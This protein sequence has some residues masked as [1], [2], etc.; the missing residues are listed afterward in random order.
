MDSDPR[1]K[2][3][4]AMALD[5]CELRGAHVD[6]RCGPKRAELGHGN[7]SLTRYREPWSTQ[8]CLFPSSSKVKAGRSV[9]PRS[10]VNNL[11]QAFSWIAYGLQ[12]QTLQ[13]IAPCVRTTA[14][15][16]SMIEVVPRFTEMTRSA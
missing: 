15:S 10:N 7:R 12:Y 14:F 4:L 1:S 11:N 2:Q 8:E 6:E 16:I 9:P 5:V 3:P 13:L